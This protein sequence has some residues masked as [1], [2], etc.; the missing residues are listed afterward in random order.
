MTVADNGPLNGNVRRPM[1]VR[2]LVHSDLSPLL[3]LYADLIRN[4][5]PLPGPAVVEAVWSESL[6]NPRMRHFGGFDGTDLVAACTICVVPNLTRACRPYAL[7]EN[8]VTA[9]TH[10]RKGWGRAVLSEAL[11]FAWSQ[12]CYKVMLLSGRKDE[13]VLRFYESVGFN[14]DDKRGFVAW[15]IA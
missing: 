15:S 10:R 13:G 12:K 9:A 5:A 14:P 2:A 1:V 7:I 4:D 8:V 6:A 11:G 3:V